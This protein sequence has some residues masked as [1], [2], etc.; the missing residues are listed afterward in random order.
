M[1]LKVLHGL[2]LSLCLIWQEGC[3]VITCTLCYL[4]CAGFYYAC[5]LTPNFTRRSGISVPQSNSWIAA[6]VRFTHQVKSE[7]HPEASRTT[8]NSGKVIFITFRYRVHYDYFSYL[9]HELRAW[10]LHYSPVV[11]AG[12]LDEDYYQHHLLLVEAVYLLLKD[13]VTDEDITQSERLLKHYCFLLSPLYGKYSCESCPYDHACTCIHRPTLIFK[14]RPIPWN[15]H[16][17]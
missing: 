3:H 17:V 11:L 10:L 16:Y 9:A 13:K 12:Y 14:D 4:V 5:G 2:E 15:L 7:G 1:E 6:F 8:S